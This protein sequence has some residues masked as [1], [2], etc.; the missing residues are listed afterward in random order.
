MYNMKVF[1]EEISCAFPVVCLSGRVL[2]DVF[3]FVFGGGGGGGGYIIVCMR[4]ARAN[5]K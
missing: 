1:Y 3:V 4:L 5:K 2:E